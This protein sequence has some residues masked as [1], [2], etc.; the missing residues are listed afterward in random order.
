MIMQFTTRITHKY[1]MGKSKHELARFYLDQIEILEKTRNALRDALDVVEVSAQWLR[2][3]GDDPDNLDA[4]KACDEVV[5]YARSLGVRR[6]CPGKDATCPCQDG[7]ACHYEGP[8]AWPIPTEARQQP[9]Q[10]GG[11]R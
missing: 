7:D 8:N 6:N 3:A 2:N 1:L 4:A 11:G 10:D 5:A 9:N